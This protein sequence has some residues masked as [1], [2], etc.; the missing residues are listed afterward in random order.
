MYSANNVRSD[1][2]FINILK[3][4]SYD[5][6]HVIYINDMMHSNEA[7]LSNVKNADEDTDDEEETAVF[8]MNIV[9]TS[10]K[11]FITLYNI[12][13][14]SLKQTMVSWLIF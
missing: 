14:E 10:K 12:E 11:T 9:K 1:L 3:Q 7:I 5:K 4:I 8:D 2:L 6:I 13:C